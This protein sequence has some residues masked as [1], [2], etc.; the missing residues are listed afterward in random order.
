MGSLCTQTPAL[1]TQPRFIFFTDFDGTVTT[2]DSNDFLT[3]ELGFG[4]EKR[5]RNS[6]DVLSGRVTFRDYFRDMLKSVPVPFDRC[7][8]FLLDHVQLDP[9]FKQFYAWA[10]ENNVPIVILSGGMRPIIQAL[11]DK[12]LDPGWEI[13]LVSNDVIPRPGK[14][15]NE[16]SGWMID[17]HDES[18]HGHDK[19]LE[20][21]KYSSL[22][23]RPVLFY[24]GD[25]VSDVSAARETDLLF[26]KADKGASNPTRLNPR[27]FA[28]VPYIGNFLVFLSS[29]TDFSFYHSDL[30]NYCEKE[31]IPFVTFRD[32][33]SILQTCK[34]IAAGSIDVRD[35]AK[36]RI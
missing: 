24:A 26:A 34:D 35:A 7:L 2:I 1:A 28:A 22:A 25:G 10:R 17:F 21:R 36:G 33:T 13:Q 9:G 29:G 32:W 6:E 15:I 31:N 27:P 8:D 5:I 16:E 3:D 4:R 18:E 23:S 19:S 12:L 14:S 20:I 30:V 11:L